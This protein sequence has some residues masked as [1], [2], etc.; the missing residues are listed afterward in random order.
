MYIYV[1]PTSAKDGDTTTL[2]GRQFYQ[3]KPE[4][5]T[6]HKSISRDTTLQVGRRD[7]CLLCTK[8]CI[9]D[10]LIYATHSV[11]RPTREIASPHEHRNIVQHSQPP[12]PITKRRHDHHTTTN[13]P[14]QPCWQSRNQ[15][16]LLNPARQTYSPAKSTTTVP[17]TRAHDTGTPKATNMAKR[18]HI[19]EG[20]SYKGTL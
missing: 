20:E 18:R 12:G 4:Q 14:I 7:G 17:S 3:V 10:N 6:R 13:Q 19:S 11:T 8:L 16:P 15:T 1:V 9:S 2:L 5:S